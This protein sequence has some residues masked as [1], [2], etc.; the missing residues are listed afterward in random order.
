MSRHPASAI[1]HAVMEYM[2]MPTLPGQQFSVPAAAVLAGCGV[3]R[4]GHGGHRDDA[5]RRRHS[6]GPDPFP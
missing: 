4:D 2:A 6:A 5:G 1:C 3:N